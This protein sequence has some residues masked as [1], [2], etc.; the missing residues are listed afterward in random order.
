MEE[1][2]AGNNN[3]QFQSQLDFT[4]MGLRVVLPTGLWGVLKVPIRPSALLGA[5]EGWH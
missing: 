2:E 5:Y 1:E 4:F 3:L